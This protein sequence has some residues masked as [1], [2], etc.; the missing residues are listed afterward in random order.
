MAIE[1][2][3]VHDS[4]T[5]GPKEQERALGPSH[6]SHG[7]CLRMI[8]GSIKTFKNQPKTGKKRFL[9]GFGRFWMVAFDQFWMI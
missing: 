5:P 2:F 6:S 3:I 7:T 1:S 9:E 8:L 4:M